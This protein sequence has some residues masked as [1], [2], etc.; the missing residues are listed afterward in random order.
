MLI[1]K[2]FRSIFIEMFTIN[3]V[4]CMHIFCIQEWANY[5]SEER[6]NT[7]ETNS[8]SVSSRILTAQKDRRQKSNRWHLFSTPSV[9]SIKFYFK[10]KMTLYS[11]NTSIWFVSILLN[12]TLYVFHMNIVETQRE[13]SQPKHMISSHSLAM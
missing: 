9:Y 11:T 6:K 13:N 5:N 2:H 12:G 4:K 3:C 7:S 1:T 8:Y 10:P